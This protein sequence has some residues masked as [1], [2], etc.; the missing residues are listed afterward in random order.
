MDDN[1][2]VT[3]TTTTDL[4]VMLEQLRHWCTRWGVHYPKVT[5]RMD[6]DKIDIKAQWL[7]LQ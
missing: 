4:M 5:V 6:A 3:T 1:R 2:V 7:P